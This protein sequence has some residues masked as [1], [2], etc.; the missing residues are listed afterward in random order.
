MFFQLFLIFFSAMVANNIILVRFLGLCSF[1]GVSNKLETSLSMS[2]AVLFVMT[3]ATFVSWN[4]YHLL[5]LPLNLVFLRTLV[6]IIVIAWLVQIVEMF[7][8]KIFPFLYRAMGVYLPLITTNCAILGTAFL[9]V[10]YKYNLV[11][12]IVFAVGVSL[13]YMLSIVVFASM[14]E[15]LENAPIP[16]SM[17]GYPI[18]FIL[19]GL[20]SLSFM[21]FIG[22]F[23]LSL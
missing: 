8:R 1:F 20:M 10:D 18:A 12:S 13:G 21:G 9:I 14:R 4:I 3:M 19:A 16:D 23:G 22:M 7:L 15:R 11:E 2:F 17:K 5:L 6:F